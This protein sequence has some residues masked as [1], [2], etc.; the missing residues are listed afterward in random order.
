MG[1]PIVLAD[2]V[3]VTTTTTGTGTY[4]LGAA[5]A[6]Y[7]D[8]A[9]AGLANG[10]RVPFAVVD[11]LTAPTKMEVGEGIYT[12]GAPATISRALIRRNTAGAAA[13]ESWGVGTK[14][15]MIAPNAANLPMLETDGNLTLP[16]ITVT[17]AIAAGT[18]LTATL[19]NV[20]ASAGAL[21]ALASGAAT[22]GQV[23]LGNTGA[24]MLFNGTTF[25]FNQ[26]LTVTGNVTWTSDRRTKAEVK[27]ARIGLARV[28]RLLPVTFRRHGA[29]RRELGLIAQDVQAAHPLAVDRG[30][31]GMLRISGPAMD[32]ILA[33]GVQA[34]AAEVAELRERVKMLERKRRA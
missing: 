32:A 20:Q 8:P 6:G 7:L 24:R 21:V 23:T 14:Y 19:G 10:A 34:L 22:Q 4:S 26:S 31:G 13:A 30:E 12:A 5:V 33:A 16:S 9:T 1:T 15:L 2:R 11:S 27:P 28:L 3:L 29:K 18:T 17:G 25:D